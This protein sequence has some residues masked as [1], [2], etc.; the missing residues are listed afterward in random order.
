MTTLN[1]PTRRYPTPDARPALNQAS[2]VPAPPDTA[3]PALL[4]APQDILAAPPAPEEPLSTPFDR[5]T[6]TP[7]APLPLC[8]TLI[9][10]G[11]LS[12]LEYRDVATGYQRGA[13]ELA[14]L[15]RLGRQPHHWAALA[16]ALHVPLRHTRQ[17]VGVLAAHLMRRAEALQRQQLVWR[18]LGGGTRAGVTLLTYD[19]AALPRQ[20]PLDSGTR[21]LDV[22]LTTPLLWRELFTLSYPPLTP[23]SLPEARALVGLFPLG[24]PPSVTPEADAEA[25]SVSLGRPFVDPLRDPPDPQ[26]LRL[27][28]TAVMRDLVVLPHHLHHGRVQLLMRDPSQTELLDRVSRLLQAP[29]D[30]LVST[31]HL[32]HQALLRAELHLT[33]ET[34]DRLFDQWSEP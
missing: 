19:P 8:L 15:A 24:D 16:Q 27:L 25:L 23:L 34:N 1:R 7:D 32:I 6:G 26:M 20:H 3:P 10:Q 33:I 17:E 31:E 14:A 22:H 28:S 9:A 18:E 29:V 4:E 2:D 11:A 21:V 5:A 13:S 30:G 12:E